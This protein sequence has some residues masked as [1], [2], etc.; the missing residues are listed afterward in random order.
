MISKS[1][2]ELHGGQ[3]SFSSEG[4]GKGS[5][6]SILLS[7]RAR[8][9]PAEKPPIALARTQGVS[10]LRDASFFSHESNV[11]RILVVDDSSTNRRMII[12]LLS[13]V[14]KQFRDSPTLTSFCFVIDDVEDGADAVEYI[15]M[16][17]TT[18]VIFIDGIMM[19][20]HGPE[21]TSKIRSL[22]FNGSI[23]AVTGDAGEESFNDF[24]VSG[25]DEL[26]SKPIS[27]EKLMKFILAYTE[28]R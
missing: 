10:W 20:M 2:I 5:T 8:E 27:K 22:G 23:V 7:V 18:D 28:V 1:I 26:I 6:F 15:R 4:E 3:L 13:H 9:T 19:K 16:N 24:M 25:A 14:E 17:P 11:I 21:A 12:K